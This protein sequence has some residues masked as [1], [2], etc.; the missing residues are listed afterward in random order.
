MK[1]EHL[2]TQLAL[3]LQKRSSFSDTIE[4]R[5][6]CVCMYV[7]THALSLMTETQKPAGLADGFSNSQVF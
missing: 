4:L 3:L 6:V 7:Y 1:T 2:I 5:T